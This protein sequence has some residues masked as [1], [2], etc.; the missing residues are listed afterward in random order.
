MP[1]KIKNMYDLSAALKEI[2]ETPEGIIDEQHIGI[3]LPQYNGT[4]AQYWAGNT[5]MP[6]L[7]MHITV[8][9]EKTKNMLITDRSSGAS[10]WITESGGVVSEKDL[11]RWDKMFMRDNPGFVPYLNLK[12]VKG[13]RTVS[14]PTNKSWLDPYKDDAYVLL[15][16]D[17]RKGIDW[18][19][20][21]LRTGIF[22]I[23][24]LMV[25]G[26]K[27]TMVTTLNQEFLKKYYGSREDTALGEVKNRTEEELALKADA[28]LIN[29]LVKVPDLEAPISEGVFRA[30]NVIDTKNIE[31]VDER[32]INKTYINF[33][34]Q[35]MRNAV[36]QVASNVLAESVFTEAI[37]T[38]YGIK[39]TKS[40]E[41]V[42]QYLERALSFV[43]TR[44]KTA[45]A[46]AVSEVFPQI[47][48]AIY[49]GGNTIK[50][51]DIF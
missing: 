42:P 10:N 11:S 39:P 26:I 2:Y 5:D 30:I 46:D 14:V 33:D 51:E 38:K 29:G 20:S 6:N 19:K 41:T 37:T 9:G 25:D 23:T 13:E 40:D 24:F 8:Y 16:G 7:R 32:G 31:K 34:P 4:Y 49:L 50:A 21:L 17:M 12:I 15:L 28:E 1:A 45:L 22:R 44:E 27:R 48:K 3:R 18:L 36:A 35:T 43:H 47:D